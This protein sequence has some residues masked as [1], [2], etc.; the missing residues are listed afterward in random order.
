MNR[1]NEKIRKK[2]KPYPLNTVELQ[3]R[4]ARYLHISSEE[5][6]KI[7]EAL[8]QKGYISYPRTETSYFAEGTDFRGLLQVQTMSSAWGEYASGLLGGRFMLPRKGKGDDQAHPPI[9]PTKHLEQGS[10]QGICMR[11]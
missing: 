11:E 6:M 5:T 8:Y 4:V 10:A 3:K 7:C 9:H 2:F 1:S